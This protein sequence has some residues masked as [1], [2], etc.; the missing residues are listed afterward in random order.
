MSL[1]E[2]DVSYIYIQECKACKNTGLYSDGSLPESYPYCDCSKGIKLRKSD[3]VKAFVA[4]K[5][6]KAKSRN[7]H[8]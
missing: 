1:V 8:S 5:K 3:R 7:R 2:L 6:L 4:R